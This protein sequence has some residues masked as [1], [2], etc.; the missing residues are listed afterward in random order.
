M[1]GIQITK[2]RRTVYFRQF[3]AGRLFRVWDG[4]KYLT[5]TRRNVRKAELLVTIILLAELKA[6]AVFT[7]SEIAFARANYSAN[8]SR[9]GGVFFIRMH[10]YI[11]CF[12]SW[13]PFYLSQHCLLRAIALASSHRPIPDI[14]WSCSLCSRSGQEISQRRMMHI[15]RTE[16][17]RCIAFIANSPHILWLAPAY[18]LAPYTPQSPWTLFLRK[19]INSPLGVARSRRGRSPFDRSGTSTR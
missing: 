11:A 18:T 7:F 4:K 12:P 1:R 15:P 6:E 9:I 10:A 3:S 13:E 2:R 16:R 5:F 19:R 8:K 17:V 14:I